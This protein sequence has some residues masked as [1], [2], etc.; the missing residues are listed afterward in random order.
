MINL[1]R[2][3]KKK[4][5]KEKE[6]GNVHILRTHC[7]SVFF[8][9]SLAGCFRKESDKREKTNMLSNVLSALL[10]FLMHYFISSLGHFIFISHTWKLGTLSQ[11]IPLADL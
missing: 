3:G 8:I 7:Q 10:L 6:K 2:P 1:N 4:R 11:T 9:K 5:N